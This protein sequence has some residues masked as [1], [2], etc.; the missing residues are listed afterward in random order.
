MH[1]KNIFSLILFILLLLAFSIVYFSFFPGG[2]SP[3]SYAMYAQSLHQAL[4]IPDMVP[5]YSIL[6]RIF[7]N[8]N[9]GPFIIDYVLVVLGIIICYKKT[10]SFLI[11][12]LMLFFLLIPSFLTTYI[13]LWKDNILLSILFVLFSIL[14]PQKNQQKVKQPNSTLNISK[15]MVWLILF[16]ATNI[17]L[18]AMSATLPFVFYIFMKNNNILF[19]FL[20][21]SILILAFL[22]LNNVIINKYVY[23]TKDI[24]L[25][26]SILFSDILKMNFASNFNIQIPESF[27]S[28][29]YN[30]NSLNDIMHKYQNYPCNDIFYMQ[31]PQYNSNH[32]IMK[33]DLTHDENELK[34]LK[35]IWGKYVLE[36]P[37]IY[38]KV[39]SYQL[40]YSIFNF[41]IPEYYR[42][43]PNQLKK[44]TNRYPKE[45][46]YKFL[47][48][49]NNKLFVKIN[50]SYMRLL[51]ATKQKNSFLSYFSNSGLWITSEIIL[52][53]LVIIFKNK[54][55]QV[56]FLITTLCSGILYTICYLPV[57]TCTDSRYFLWSCCVL[58]LSI[59]KL[60]L[61]IKPLPTRSK[62]NPAI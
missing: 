9:F 44:Y 12:I 43:D 14:L 6:W 27:T 29:Y 31:V 38:L 46:E 17:R 35:T 1:I 36:H 7:N 42:F 5:I 30:K 33:T 48:N 25:Y 61:S 24:N 2:F 22:V 49:Y 3:D 15:F 26:Q 11:P 56:D 19:S 34:K 55:S 50:E 32:P 39:K 51:N 54:I 47:V 59:G 40:A 16:F 60:I 62:N 13:Y 45:I 41:N 28:S 57:L 58:I 52:L 23:N 21:S 20:K 10:E 8:Y 53:I 18:N 37:I 4:F